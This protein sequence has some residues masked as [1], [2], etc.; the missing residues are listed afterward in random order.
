MIKI[1][2]I[3]TNSRVNAYIVIRKSFFKKWLYYMKK[4]ELSHQ[5]TSYVI[6]NVFTFISNFSPFP[7]SRTVGHLALCYGRF[8]R[9]VDPHTQASPWRICLSSFKMADVCSNRPHARTKCTKLCCSAGNLVCTSVR[10][11]TSWLLNLK[12]FLPINSW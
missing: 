8:S 10:I 4:G 5:I 6:T 3:T 7:L 1:A 11:S 2:S 9:W 12:A